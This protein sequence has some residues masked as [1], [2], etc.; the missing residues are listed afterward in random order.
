VGA[1]ARI[2]Q[3]K[4]PGGTP[5]RR[6]LSNDPFIVDIAHPANAGL[7]SYLRRGAEPT[8]PAQES[9]ASIADPYYQLG[10]HPDLVEQL[11][12]KITTHLP[13]D[14][15]WVVYRRPVLVHPRSGILF[16]FA[17]G[18]HL[19]AL[20]LPEP[21]Q[22]AALAAGA[23]RRYEIRGVLSLDL[24]EVGEPWVLGAWRPQEPRWCRAAFDFAAPG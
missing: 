12:D 15:R 22:T 11:W 18:T 23:A 5:R 13:L 14:C 20:R 1:P 24:D 7:L 4:R 2:I 9:P 19:Y 10:T 3:P 8:T 17:Q 16:G 21:E 6:F